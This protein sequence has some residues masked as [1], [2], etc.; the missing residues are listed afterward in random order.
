V[1]LDGGRIVAEGTHEELLQSTERYRQ[2]LA[3][4]GAVLPV[5]G[6]A[7]LAE[8]QIWWQA[9]TIGIE[10]IEQCA[11]LAQ[12]TGAVLV[13]APVLGT[14]LPA[15]EGKLVV[16]ASGPDSALDACAPLFDA[17]G[18]RTMRLGPA[19]RFQGTPVRGGAAVRV[20]RCRVGPGR[21]EARDDPASAEER[22]R[23]CVPA[24][25]PRRCHDVTRSRG[26][27]EAPDRQE[28]CRQ[29]GKGSH[30]DRHGIQRNEALYGRC[31]GRPGR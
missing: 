3:Q 31:L 18:Q 20:G 7:S 6:R 12:E 16:L 2:V 25:L 24:I 10:G 14:R 28:A 19:G 9:S 13:D 17:V 21:Q 29:R 8:G 27:Q 30:G 5:A 4:T 11:A 1:L 22:R 23:A 26:A 15:E